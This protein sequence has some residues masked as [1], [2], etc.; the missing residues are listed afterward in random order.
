MQAVLT[1][2]VL[3]L[4]WNKPVEIHEFFQPVTSDIELPE[5]RACLNR[6]DLD[7]KL[8]K[9]RV[10]TFVKNSKFILPD[11]VARVQGATLPLARGNSPQCSD[12]G[13]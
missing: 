9:W 6:T 4:T 5:Y 10:T 13:F 1:N 3:V 8:K 12:S 7:L 2:S 11:L